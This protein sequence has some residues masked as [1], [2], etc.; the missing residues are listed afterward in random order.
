MAG[1]PPQRKHTRRW[2]PALT[3]AVPVALPPAAFAADIFLGL[4]LPTWLFGILLAIGLLATAGSLV[5]HMRQARRQQQ[6]LDATE[7]TVIALTAALPAYLMPLADIKSR[8]VNA[9]EPE[10]GA[11]K[12]ELIRAAVGSADNDLFPK[13]TRCCYFEL[14]GGGEEPRKLACIAYS[15]RS[16][17]FECPFVEGVGISAP[18]I[19][20]KIIDPQSSELRGELTKEAFH[21][22]DEKLGFKSGIACAVFSGC[23]TFGM[24][25]WDAPEV[26]ALDQTHLNI[27]QLLAQD[28]G[29]MLAINRATHVAPGSHQQ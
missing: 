5:V 23:K 14:T 13:R 15:G 16:D 20:N 28:L 19:F 8:L 17:K 4:P 10:L 24:L 6:R 25:T 18:Y 1:D 3:T 9:S 21:E 22:W 27:A 7:K 26:N 2:S 12:L 29:T 11:R